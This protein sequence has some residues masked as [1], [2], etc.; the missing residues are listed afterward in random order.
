VKT[1]FEAVREIR[2]IP[3]L[4]NTVI[5][6]VSASVL[7]LDGQKSRLLGFDSFVSKPVEEKKLFAALQHHLKLEWIYES[8]E[9]DISNLLNQEPDFS[10]NLIAPPPEEL[11]VLYQLAMLG[12]MKKIRERAVYL[13]ELDEQ[14]APLA[15]QLKD[16]SSTFQEKAIVNLIEQYLP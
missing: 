14:Y 5:I 12:S 4:K 7:E 16:L 8:V 9:S 3:H 15:A 13:E 6:A 1:G 11:E 10:D 2:E